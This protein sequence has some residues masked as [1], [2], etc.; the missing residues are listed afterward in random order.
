MNFEILKFENLQLSFYLPFFLSHYFIIMVT[1]TRKSKRGKSVAPH[2]ASS[3]IRNRCKQQK[4]K[5]TVRS[6][7][8][9]PVPP[10]PPAP[11]AEKPS[12]APPSPSAYPASFFENQSPD[13]SISESDYEP[14]DYLDPGQVSNIINQTN[15]VIGDSDDRIRNLVS[16]TKKYNLQKYNAYKKFFEAIANHPT[17][18][19]L[20]EEVVDPYCA[21]GSK[22]HRLIILCRGVKTK[23]KYNILNSALLVTA[24]N[25]KLAS[26]QHVD[27]SSR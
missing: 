5:T 14:I 11:P 25:V 27:I 19:H 13:P 23:E 26:H 16:T 12:P 9:P 18:N 2:S 7:P 6:L 4:K 8:A 20:A 3:V 15:V 22:E 21:D 1:Q 10:A 17:L 24:Q